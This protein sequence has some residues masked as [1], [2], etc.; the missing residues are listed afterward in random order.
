MRLGVNYPPGPPEW[1]ERLGPANV[2]AAL[3]SPRHETGAERFAPRPLLRSM[4][5]LGLDS[6]SP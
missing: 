3:E 5:S 2:M 4:V 1:A 6:F